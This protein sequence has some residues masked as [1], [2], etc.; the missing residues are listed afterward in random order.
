MTISDEDVPCM[1]FFH[2]VIFMYYLVTSDGEAVIA[3]VMDE[4]TI[5]IQCWFIHGSDALGCKVVLVSDHPSVNNETMNISRNDMLA[6]GTF[7]FI[8]PSSCYSRIFASD[9]EANITDS[10]SLSD[11]NIEGEF[12]PNSTQNTL[13]SS[14]ISSF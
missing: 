3:I 14:M 5:N 11:L 7:N 9:I 12:Q 8:R 4:S 10:E 1:L 13:C 2:R 6:S